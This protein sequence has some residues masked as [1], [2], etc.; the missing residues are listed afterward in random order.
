MKKNKTMIALILS[1][2]LLTSC[3]GKTPVLQDPA[4]VE[5]GQIEQAKT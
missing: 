3:A 2:V 4:P 1:A 5:K